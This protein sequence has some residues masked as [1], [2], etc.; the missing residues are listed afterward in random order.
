MTFNLATML[1]EAAAAHPDKP[2]CLTDEGTVGYGEL[3]RDAASVAA[4]L[5]ADG[6]MAGDRIALQLPT[7]P[8][9]LATYFGILRAGA[10]MVPLNPQ[11][12]KHEYDY[13]LADSGARLHVIDPADVPRAE[14]RDH[15]APTAPDDTA[16]IIYTS[17]TTGRPKGAELTH[18]QLFLSATITGEV[19]GV[20][21]DDVSLAV[22]PFFHV[23]G[24][25]GIANVVMRYATTLAFLDRF[26]PGPALDAM[27]RHRVSVLPGVPTMFYALLTAD[28]SGRDLS[29]FRVASS[30]GASLPGAVIERFEAEFGVPILEGYGLTETT[31]TTTMNR[32]GDRRALSVGKPLWGVDLRIVSPD[33]SN[34]PPG[35]D[36]VGEV[37][38]RGFNV[39]KGYHG[40]PVATEQTV[41]DGWLHT[42]DLGYVDEDG[43][44]FIVD[45]LK[46]LI[47]RGGYNVYPR[48]VEEVLY[49]HPAVAEAAVV[50]RPDERLGEEVVAFVAPRPGSSIDVDEALAHCEQQL[51]R[52]KRPREMHVLPELPKTPSGKLTKKELREKADHA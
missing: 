43:F 29:A 36:N 13:L 39:M 11:L 31:S 12:T 1:R 5:L 19:F 14:P 51:A 21:Q 40:N 37:L 16:V 26:E 3:D 34:L 10:V 49:A 24:L 20:Q 41:R 27:E 23:Y 7:G 33:G 44:L 25:S 38:I 2:A 8:D 46:D 35:S 9:F 30:G 45:R 42:G 47:I 32:H 17:G 22:V 18:V 4:G 6:V 50:G 48:E 52:Y 15:L 28:P